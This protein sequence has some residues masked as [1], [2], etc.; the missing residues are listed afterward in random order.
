[1]AAALKHRTG[2]QL[3]SQGS[4]GLNRSNTRDCAATEVW[5]GAFSLHAEPAIPRRRRLTR[6]CSRQAAV[7]RSSVRARAPSRPDS[8]DIGLCGRGLDGLQLIC[9]PLGGRTRLS[10][11]QP[12]QCRRRR[13]ARRVAAKDD[14]TPAPGACRR[15]DDPDSVGCRR[16]AG[17][18]LGVRCA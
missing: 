2:G 1:L 5:C 12:A 13:T 11:P 17:L 6:K 9:I 10:H 8:G 3:S 15:L 18:F 14:G 7:G 4:P 16:G